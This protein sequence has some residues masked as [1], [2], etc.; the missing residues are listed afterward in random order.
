ML[1]KKTIA[2]VAVFAL[3]LPVWGF[4]RTQEEQKMDPQMME[5][6]MKFATPNENH[7]YFQK[8]IGTWEIDS[9]SWMQPGVEPEHNK[10][11]AEIKTILG[12]RFMHAVFMGTMMGQPFEGLQIVG[13]DNLQNKY[14]TFWID[15]AGTAFY[16]T[17]GTMDESGKVLTET[18]V[19][20][21]PITGGSTK[22]R[23]VTTGLDEDNFIYEMYMTGPDGQEFKVLE[24]NAKRKK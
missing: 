8:F 17:S 14:I 23:A 7:A 11:T 3:I 18:G 6:W 20:P 9:K 2:L 15:N 21:D 10:I 5:V 1:S 4:S 16:L 13:Y 19:W 22:V 24:N 12:G